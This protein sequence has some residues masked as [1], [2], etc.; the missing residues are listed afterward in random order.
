MS[1]TDVA[2]HFALCQQKFIASKVSCGTWGKCS[3]V[4]H[5]KHKTMDYGQQETFAK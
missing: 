3:N 1:I 4:E 2:S 5:L